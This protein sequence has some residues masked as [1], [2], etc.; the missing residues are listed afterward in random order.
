[1]SDVITVHD[2]NQIDFD[3]PGKTLYEVAFHYDGTWGNAL[4][5]LAVINGTASNEAGE[6]IRGVACF[7]GTHGNEY[8]GQVAVWRLMHE[9][10]PAEISGRVIL[11]PRLNQPACNTGTRQSLQDGVNMNR[12]FPGD[13]MGTLTYRIADFVT[14]RVFPLVE[15]VLDIHAGGRGIEFALCSSFHMVNDPAQYE[16]MKQVA[17]LFDTPFIFIYSSGM[18]RGL[19]TDQAEALG[20][21]TIGGEFGHSHGVH[22]RGVRHAYQGI[23]NVLRHYKM[24]PGEIQRV[25]P[26]REHPPRLVAAIDLEDYVPAPVTGVFEPELP[27]GSAVEAGQL[28]GRLYDFERVGQPPMPVHAPSSGYILLQPF[29][30]P[31]AKGDTMLVIGQEVHD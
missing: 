4:V 7:G 26:E 13:P 19:L 24:L 27:V 18:A 22:Q 17:S 30:A 28:V 3:R 16:E 1:M 31:I 6:A 23:K 8:E 29:Q 10:E 9:L 14:T 15:V 5:P 11:M 21:V 12:A 25:A 20:K 2:H